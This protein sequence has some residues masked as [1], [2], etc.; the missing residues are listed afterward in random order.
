[1]SQIIYI[2]TYAWLFDQILILRYYHPTLPAQPNAD[3]VL[4]SALGMFF[5]EAA[6]QYLTMTVAQK[7]SANFLLHEE[8][9]SG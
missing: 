5:I 8:D 2:F 9:D 7:R 1:M 3:M 6:T 4:A